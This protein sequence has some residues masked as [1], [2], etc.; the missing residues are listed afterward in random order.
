MKET[1]VI[2][3]AGPAGL[4]AA[5]EC[6]QSGRLRPIVLEA[7]DDL[8]GISRT[9]NV[10][11]NRMDIGG[12]RFFS[13]SDRVMRW[14]TRILP[15]D[16]QANGSRFLLKYQGAHRELIVD[17]PDGSDHRNVMLIRRRLSRILHHGKLFSYPLKLDRHTLRS[18][19]AVKLSRIV[20]SYLKAK[21][22]QR[23]EQS[24]EDFYINRFGGELYRTFFKDYTEKVWGVPCS[25]IAPDW[26]S[27]RI[28]GLSISETLLHAVRQWLRPGTESRETSLIEH[29][30]YPKYGPGQ[31]WETVAEQVRG[32]GG[33]VQTGTRITGVEVEAGRVRRVQA[34]RANGSRQ[35]LE[36]DHFISTMPINELVKALHGL[37][38]PPAVRRVAEELPFRDFITVGVLLSSL[39]T[40]PLQDNW[41]YIHDPRVQVGRLQIFNNW[42]PY[43]VQDPSTTWVGLEYF[44][45]QGDALWCQNDEQLAARAVAE[46]QTLGLAQPCQVLDT[47]VV[48][49][50]K[51]YPAYFGSYADFGQ[52]RALLDPIENLY[53][54]GRNG[55]HRYNN[56]DHSMLTAMAAVEN[57]LSGRRDKSNLWDVNVEGDYHE[58]RP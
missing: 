6:V 38:V 41:I 19:G 32:G 47:A 46:L 16:S 54:V 40:G 56:Q 15:L 13:K 29:F 17:T 7:S 10:R 1:V 49:V 51:A 28:K 27:Q 33:E 2:I 18:L 5:W 23:P 3:G 39:Q 26:G 45:S 37:Q 35:W 53:L 31:M 8:G 57:M 48:R 12:H 52:L 25:S 11:G 44:V 20:V 24:L 14:W 58:E 4:T 50:P 21:L 30:L 55:M 9:V 36:G 42:S 43:L 22:K 34:T